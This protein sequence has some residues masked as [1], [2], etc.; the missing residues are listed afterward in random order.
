M[1]TNNLACVLSIAGTDPSG[2]AGIHAD[3]KAISATGSYAAAVITALVAQNTEGVQAIETISAGFVQKQL[4]S[5]LDDLNVQ[6]I[7]IGMLHDE[8]IIDVVCQTLSQ[9]KSIPIVFDP[10]MV[11]KDG[12]PLLKPKTLGKLKEKLLSLAYLITPNLPEAEHLLDKSIRSKEDMQTAAITIGQLYKTNVLLKGGHLNT[13]TSSDVL[14]CLKEDTCHW[15]HAKRVKT[16]NTHG[17]GCSLSS[18]IAS[19]LA[20]DFSLWEAITQAKHYLTQAILSGKRYQLGHGHGPVDH[21]YFL[22]NRTDEPCK[23]GLLRRRKPS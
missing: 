2:G 15:F 18:A 11:A 6:T 12:S 20:Q 9:F 22:E 1:T 5:V 8:P 21:F 3:I 7:K 16:K 17:T 14:Y 19:Y 23:P 10:V 4:Q 13:D